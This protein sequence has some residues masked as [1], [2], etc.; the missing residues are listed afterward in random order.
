MTFRE[1]RELLEALPDAVVLL[2]YGDVCYLNREAERL[3][4]ETLLCS[5]PNAV[6]G[7][8][9]LAPGRTVSGDLVI[10]GKHCAVRAAGPARRR[11]LYLTALEKTPQPGMTQLAVETISRLS[12]LCRLGAEQLTA[13]GGRENRQLRR[14]VGLLRRAGYAMTRVS[15]GLGTLWNAETGPA[16][17]LK[18]AFDLVEL[19][20]QVV[21]TVRYLL[22]DEPVR[23]TWDS[24]VDR[25][26]YYGDA[27]QLQRMAL[28]LLT[29]AIHAS[30]GGVA[31]LI[32]RADSGTVVQVRELG[33]GRVPVRPRDSAWD[34]AGL[35]LSVARA[36]A[37]AHGGRLAFA[38]HA[39]GGTTASVYLPDT[40]IP[41]DALWESAG[42]DGS[43]E[44]MELYL[45]ELSPL[46]E[47]DAYL[48]AEEREDT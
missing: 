36:I 3:L 30:T 8:L 43:G 1:L 35:G 37:A 10:S 23:V 20:G 4:G 45:S 6:F 7:P 28:N 44:P 41:A 33:P 34:D 18:T 47:G 39:D 13:A 25:V 27:V 9:L 31:L 2:R 46:L 19:M 40:S 16:P 11:I 42:S 12:G 32:A 29:S 5:T 17:L 26:Y 24:A 48:R 38:S 15:D 22:G 14:S 21:G